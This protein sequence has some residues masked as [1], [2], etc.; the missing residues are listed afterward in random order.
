MRKVAWMALQLPKPQK[1]A[2]DLGDRVGEHR[3]EGVMEVRV[4][5]NR[6]AGVVAKLHQQRKS[7]ASTHDERV[8]EGSQPHLFY[9]LI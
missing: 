6:D 4:D 9:F 1:K 3:Q 5:G 8:A 2:E 7:G